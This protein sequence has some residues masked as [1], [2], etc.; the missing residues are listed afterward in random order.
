MPAGTYYI[1]DLCYV[2]TDEEWDEF[3]SLT[4]KDNECIHGEFTFKDGRR[5]ATYGTKWGD[6]IYFDLGKKY[7]FSVDAGLIGCFRVEDIRAEKYEDIESLGAIVKFDYDF[8][9]KEDDG[10]ITF[11][12]LTIDTDPEWEDEEEEYYN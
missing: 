10:E 12:R 8:I 11:G 7:E 1:G 3:C 4:I 5:F 6:G 9:T 2:M